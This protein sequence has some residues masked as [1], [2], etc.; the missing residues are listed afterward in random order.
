MSITITLSSALILMGADVLDGFDQA[1][2]KFAQTTQK[3][4]CPGEVM[5]NLKPNP[6][7]GFDVGATSARAATLFRAGFMDAQWNPVAKAGFVRDAPMGCEYAFMGSTGSVY[8]YKSIPSGQMCEMQGTNAFLCKPIPQLEA[9]PAK[10]PT[11]APGSADI[12]KPTCH[13]GC[14]DASASGGEHSATLGGHATV[15]VDDGEY[16]RLVLRSAGDEGHYVAF[17]RQPGG[18]PRAGTAYTLSNTCDEDN[19]ANRPDDFSA[20][21][22]VDGYREEAEQYQARSGTLTIDSIG[23]TWL[24]GHF[25][26]VGCRY[27]VEG[28]IKEARVSGTFEGLWLSSH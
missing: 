23:P 7:D 20:E 15:E 12:G 14:F 1:T 5:V 16:F 4:T 2:Q 8:L 13:G 21:Y 10:T 18:P 26:F 25:A 27:T 11:Q 19:A 28:E 9:P 22:V 17:G 6:K 3:Y 24:R